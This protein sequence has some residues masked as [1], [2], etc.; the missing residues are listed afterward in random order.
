MTGEARLLFYDNSVLRRILRETRTVAMIGASPN[1]VRPSSFAM[2]YLQGKGYRVIP[3][4]PRAAGAAILGETVYARLADVPEPV[5]VVDIFRS[6]DAAGAATDEAIAQADALAIKVVWMQLGV[7]NDAAA[8]R[9]EDAGLTV[10]MDRC[11]KIEYGRLF[12]EI[13]WAGVNSG[14]ISS[15]RPRLHP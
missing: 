3:V 10:I 12:G 8:R 15:K 13:G 9:A 5:Q 4:N 1:W 11:M 7:R 14:I 2:K 6:G